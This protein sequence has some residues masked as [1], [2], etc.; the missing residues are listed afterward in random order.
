[1]SSAEK[2]ARYIK[3][4]LANS[5]ELLTK[6][7][8]S[9]LRFK[10]IVGF[11]PPKGTSVFLPYVKCIPTTSLLPLYDTLVVGI[12]K[13]E[14]VGRFGD[15][16]GLAFNDVIALAQEGKLIPFID[17]DCI[18]CLL[19]MSDVVQQLVDN[20][21]HLFLGGPQSA[22]L[23][24]KTAE[25]V[26]VDYESGGELAKKLS[27]VTEDEEEKEKRSKV[28]AAFKQLR[29][30]SSGK[31]DSETYRSKPHTRICASIKPTAE[32]IRQLIKMTKEGKPKEY[33]ETLEDRLYMIPKFLL[34]KAFNSTF[35]TNAGCRYIA[36]VEN[37]EAPIKAESLETVD[38]Y[39]L[40]F[41]ERKLHIAYS[42]G[43]SLAEYSDIF[44]SKT[45]NSMRRIFG[46]IISEASSKG[47]SLISLQ[48]SIEE[49]N[50]QVE[51]LIA[52]ST[53]RAKIV[54]ATS[55]IL[56]ANAGAIKMLMEGVAEKY[57]NAPQKAWDCFIVPER[58]RNR[59]SEWLSE[60]AVKLESKLAGV[61]PDVIHLYNTRT[62]VEQLMKA[63]KTHGPD[64]A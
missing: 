55:D 31:A 50:Q 13:I 26:G 46:Q 54:Y 58:Y 57:I 11:E 64:S 52:R 3:D 44:D 61:S 10:D 47:R 34:A 16:T 24:L 62:C 20:D 33:V 5:I 4:V 7:D 14:K 18:V 17:V 8:Y 42:E 41:I 51:E 22:L 39:M 29:K 6:Q 25:P 32:Y 36:K 30:G 38:P 27:S 37:F 45:T 12:P 48:N 53:K 63:S 40:E 23:A 43:L 9:N 21:V 56:R 60:K 19:E 28:E 1:M 35:S 49:Y 59:M 2:G 15:L